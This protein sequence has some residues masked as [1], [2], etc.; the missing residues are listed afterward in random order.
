MPLANR[1][2][3]RGEA[4]STKEKRKL[5]SVVS[6]ATQIYETPNHTFTAIEQ[7]NAQGRASG[8]RHLFAVREAAR[9]HEYRRYNI[10]AMRRVSRSDDGTEDAV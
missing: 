9:D 4:K 3:L 7:A 8:K 6:P 2:T 10:R 5:R 1:I